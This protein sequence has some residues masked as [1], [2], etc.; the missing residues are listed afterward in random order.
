M[1]DHSISTFFYFQNYT[2]PQC[3]SGFIE[4]LE[5]SS[6]EGSSGME[7]NSEDMS[8]VDVDILGYV[9]KLVKYYILFSFK[10]F[11]VCNVKSIVF[12]FLFM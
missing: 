7:V 10:V 3:A 8:D 11:Y 4:E 6:N 12:I 2:C 9:S 5:S 1:Y